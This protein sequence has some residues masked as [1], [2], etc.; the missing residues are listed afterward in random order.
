MVVSNTMYLPV[1]TVATTVNVNCA[2]KIEL[3]VL[4]QFK[5][6][7]IVK[8]SYTSNYGHMVNSTDPEICILKLFNKIMLNC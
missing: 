5:V 2:L 6:I 8:G 7:L 3:I 1:L 4:L